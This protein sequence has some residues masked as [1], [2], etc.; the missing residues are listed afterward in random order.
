MSW[1]ATIAEPISGNRVYQERARRALPL[2]VRQAEA[3]E[4]IFYSDLAQELGIS[5][6]R[7]LNYPL[8]SIGKTI[9]YLSKVRKEKIPPIQC[10]VINKRTGLPGEGVG[11]FLVKKEDFSRLSKARQREIVKAQLAQIFAY[12]NWRDVLKSLSLTYT[13]PNFTNLFREASNRGAGGESEHHHRL[14]DFV[15]RNPGQ[16]GL[17]KT[18]PVGRTE[19]PLPSGDYLDVSFAAGNDWIAV[20]V[21]SSI[22]NAADITRGLFQ[23]VKYRAV[24]QGVQVA[25]GDERTARAVLVLETRLPREL[26][27]LKHLLGVEVFEE[28]SPR[29]CDEMHRR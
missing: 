18:I 6:P 1:V 9:E 29:N 10:L 2:L 24:M 13:P 3:G 20:E 23:C 14:K 22:S 26:I 7:T 25:K 27:P 11:W 19:V 8:G 5:N 28:V 15:A 17:P 4:T 16:I 12:S 21:K